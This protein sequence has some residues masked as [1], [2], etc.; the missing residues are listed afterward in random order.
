MKR[1]FKIHT[2]AQ[3]SRTTE[4]KDLGVPLQKK[5]PG[6]EERKGLPKSTEP[7]REG[8]NSLTTRTLV[9]TEPWPCTFQAH[10]SPSSS[11]TQ[12]ISSKPGGQAT[13]Q[14]QSITKEVRDVGQQVEPTCLYNPSSPKVPKR[15]G[16]FRAVFS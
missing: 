9:L 1:V 11:L 7:D 4:H 6:L 16:N 2:P 12:V 10:D 14:S 5:T 8:T 13:L 15:S 3:I